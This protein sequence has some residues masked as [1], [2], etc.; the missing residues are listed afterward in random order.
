MRTSHARLSLALVGTSGDQVGVAI[1][2]TGWYYYL[3]SVSLSRLV[4]IIAAAAHSLNQPVRCR[5]P[6]RGLEPS[7]ADDEYEHV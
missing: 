2:C 3:P 5:R 7:V 6:A 1:V 4:D